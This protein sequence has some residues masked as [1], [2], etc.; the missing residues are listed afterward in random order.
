[1]CDHL[2]S[3]A[4]ST[5]TRFSVPCARCSEPESRGPAESSY[6]QEGE[7]REF[8]R[9]VRPTWKRHELDQAKEKLDKVGIK[10]VEQL[11]TAA[12]G[13]TLNSRLEAL[14]EKKFHRATLDLVRKQWLLQSAFAS[15]STTVRQNG[16][17]C[18]LR[19]LRAKGLYD[20]VAPSLPRVKAASAPDLSAYRSAPPDGPERCTTP[21]DIQRD[22][23]ARFHALAHLHGDPLEMGR[24]ARWLR[25]QETEP[26]DREALRMIQEDDG[27]QQYAVLRREIS[28]DPKMRRYYKRILQAKQPHRAERAQTQDWQSK[29]SV[30]EVRRA[31]GTLAS[32]RRELGLLRQTLKSLHEWED[33]DIF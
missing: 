9:T 17:H 11:A 29:R 8:L 13:N 6:E 14:G 25:D 20:A 33:R 15:R 23:C 30:K 3:T 16:L 21:A 26:W 4:S 32:Q 12:N 10:S 2:Q 7:L 5:G 19:K 27:L 22:E 31:L 1:M 28:A 24:T 18:P